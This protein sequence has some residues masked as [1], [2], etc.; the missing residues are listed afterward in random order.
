MQAIIFIGFAIFGLLLQVG[1]SPGPDSAAMDL[2]IAVTQGAAERPAPVASQLPGT[3]LPQRAPPPRT[4][5]A[6]WP[7]FAG[8]AVT[9]VGIVIY[10]LTFSGRL[11]RVGDE[12]GRFA[13]DQPEK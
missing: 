3:G 5:R 9:W 8:F 11:R 7:V 13:A 10:T 2:E 4:L 12:I 1:A 6:F